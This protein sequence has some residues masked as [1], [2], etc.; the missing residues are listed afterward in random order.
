[1][2]IYSVAWLAGLAPFEL[3]I[4]GRRVT[5]G[6]QQP[7]ERRRPASGKP[8][9]SGFSFASEFIPFSADE[10][11]QEAALRSGLRGRPDLI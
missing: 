7:G 2:H 3:E 10:G 8:D 5:A 6:L 11:S 4:G 1:M 9:G